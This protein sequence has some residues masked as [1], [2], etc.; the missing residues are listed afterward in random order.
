MCRA[1]PEA[2]LLYSITAGVTVGLVAWLAFTLRSAKEPW[3]RPPL[4][5]AD[6]ALP[7]TR[8]AS[9]VLS[10]L[11]GPPRSDADSTSR[12]TPVA[13]SEG[14]ART[15]RESEL[16]SDGDETSRKARL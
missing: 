8:T 7:A 12:A 6:T 14:K 10:P 15:A 5:A 11:D 9:V 4:E 16:R 13:L 3:I 1:M 2:T